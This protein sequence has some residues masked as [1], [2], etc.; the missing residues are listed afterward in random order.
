MIFLR[1]TDTKGIRASVPQDRKIKELEAVNRYRE[2]L[3]TLP[4]MSKACLASF[5][6]K[7]AFQIPL[8]AL[9]SGGADTGVRWLTCPEN[10]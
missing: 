10:L 4:S 5:L 7:R 8:V 9:K 6:Y 1:L 3:D 2:V